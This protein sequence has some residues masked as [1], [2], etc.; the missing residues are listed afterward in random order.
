MNES[1]RVVEYLTQKEYRASEALGSSDIKL[2]L[3]NPYAFKNKIKKEGNERLNLG[4]AIH[5]LIL[6]PKNFERDFFIMPDL[7]LRLVDDRKKK[8][9]L[10][11]EIKDT[12]KLVISK[13]IFQKA[14]SVAEAFKKN[15]VSKLITGEGLVECSFFDEIE[16]IPCKC[17]P[18]F[19]D[20]TKEIIYDLKT[21]KPG[22]ANKNEFIK[23]VANYGYYIQAAFYLKL[24]GAKKF[25]FISL[26]IEPPYM[27][28][29]YELDITSLEF[30]ESEII[31]A[32]EIYKN[33]DKY[34]S[35]CFLDNKDFSKVQT[36][37]LPNYVYY[38]D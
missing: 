24:T 37:T 3:E 31:R 8:K 11:K 28:G 34:K 17:R 23:S 14:M 30:G 33:L 9:D 22:G 12:D 29:I 27:V 38:K 25:Y 21:T 26:E 1:V 19:Y 32:L 36:I 10:E 13:D 18:D 16:G 4:S 20:D 5:S 35:P 15:S 2:I 6:E 7:N